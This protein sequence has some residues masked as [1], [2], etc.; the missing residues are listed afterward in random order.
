MHSM[1]QLK[2]RIVSISQTRQMTATMKVVALAKLKKNAGKVQEKLKQ[3]Y[4]S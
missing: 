1:K 2:N 4:L 3:R